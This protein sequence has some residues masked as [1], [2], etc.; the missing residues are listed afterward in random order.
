MSGIQLASHS[1]DCNC[2][3]H[4]DHSPWRLGALPVGCVL[5]LRHR[6]SHT[7]RH[8][9]GKCLY[10]FWLLIDQFSHMFDNEKGAAGLKVH[11]LYVLN[12]AVILTVSVYLW[13][14]FRIFWG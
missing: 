8:L 6:S 13:D 10:I 11:L 1:I 5:Y 12:N 3:W 7:L 4:F 2:Y 14:V 9:C